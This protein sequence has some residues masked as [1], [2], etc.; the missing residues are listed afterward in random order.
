MKTN[1]FKYGM[2]ALTMAFAMTL[3]FSCSKDDEDE[4]ADIYAE[5]SSQLPNPHC[6]GVI[7]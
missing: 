4:K 2:F 6:R 5:D 7:T 3:C 1:F